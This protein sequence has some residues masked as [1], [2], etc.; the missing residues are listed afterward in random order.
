VHGESERIFLNCQR[1]D[2]KP[3]FGQILEES[4][5]RASSASPTDQVIDLGCDGRWNDQGAW[6]S[7][8]QAAN[9]AVVRVAGVPKRN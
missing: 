3:L 6:L 1:T 8:Q 2:S 4:S 9:A 5:G 7:L